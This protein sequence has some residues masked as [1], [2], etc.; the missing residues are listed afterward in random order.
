[1]P[2]CAIR[3]QT[4]W[5]SV[6]IL[7]FALFCVLSY[8]F[9]P[10]EASIPTSVLSRHTVHCPERSICVTGLVHEAKGRQN[11]QA[12]SVFFMIFSVIL[13]YGYKITK[14][15]QGRKWNIYRIR[16][17]KLRKGRLY[18]WSGKRMVSL[19]GKSNYVFPVLP[20]K[21]WSTAKEVLQYFQR[22]TTVLSKKYCNPP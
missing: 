7:K 22:S 10:K 17:K 4:L 15:K 19:Q 6:R 16:C 20:W 5:L 8:Y 21:Y 12:I 11:N 9:P 2:F 1:M 13:Y 14:N 3:S 18:R